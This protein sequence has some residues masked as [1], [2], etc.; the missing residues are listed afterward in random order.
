MKFLISLA[1]FVVVFIPT[2]YGIQVI[3]RY[4]NGRRGQK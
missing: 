4:L 3:R 2:K 1:I